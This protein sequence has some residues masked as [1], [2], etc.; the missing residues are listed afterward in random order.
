MTLPPSLQMVTPS[1]PTS[2]QGWK[3]RIVP[4]HEPTEEN[5]KVLP[6]DQEML[7]RTTD[8]FRVV[9][10]VVGFLAHLVSRV[11]KFL[12]RLIRSTGLTWQTETVINFGKEVVGFP[13]YRFIEGG[14]KVTE[15][16]FRV[17]GG[18]FTLNM[19]RISNSRQP[20]EFA[21]MGLDGEPIPYTIETVVVI[22]DPAG[23]AIVKD[24]PAF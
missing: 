7:F 4:G 6:G 23:D 3:A 15:W 19:L 17:R 8:A 1:T 24:I 21:F 12:A 2:A 13:G 9:I 5:A 10:F 20:M 22:D 14:G 11:S 16:R 18:P